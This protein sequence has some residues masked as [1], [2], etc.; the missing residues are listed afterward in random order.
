[1]GAKNFYLLTNSSFYS[2]YLVSK[3]IDTF[4]NVEGFQGII[5]KEAPQLQRLLDARKE[6]HNRY[7]DLNSSL[8]LD[9][10]LMK[11]CFQQAIDLYSSFD[12]TE[13][14][15]VEKYGVS[16]YSATGCHKTIFINNLNSDEARGWLEDVSQESPPF[17]FVCASQILKSWWID[18]TDGHLFNCHSAV[19]PFARGMHAI[20]NIAIQEDIAAFK[21]AAGTTIH[22]IDDGIDTGPIIRA[23]RIQNPFKF[24]SI[25]ELKAHSFWLG[26]DLYVKTAQEILMDSETTPAGVVPNPELLG[27]NFLSKDFT[28]ERQAQA[29]RA[30][31]SMKSSLEN[32]LI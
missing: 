31:L 9:N 23:Q 10:M 17:I 11:K 4:E 16:K 30:Y 13:Q 26:F 27:P 21:E 8:S 6:F 15:M 29:E 25:W 14:A 24:R 20:E 7:F 5:V 12:Q 18:L 1:M 3:W 22:Y 19:L 2:S 28:S 32:T